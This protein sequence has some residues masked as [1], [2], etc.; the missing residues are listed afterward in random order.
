MWS[1]A[2]CTV[3]ILDLMQ[4]NSL[5]QFCINLCNEKLQNHYVQCVFDQEI[6]EYK[7]EASCPA[8]V[9][10]PPI[11]IMTRGRSSV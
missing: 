6:Q 2:Y 5:E 1:A 3:Y 8:S 4:V 10:H 11:I 9:P 7:E